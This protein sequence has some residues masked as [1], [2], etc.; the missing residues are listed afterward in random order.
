MLLYDSLGVSLVG[1]STLTKSSGYSF[2]GITPSTYAL[3]SV[4]DNYTTVADKKCLTSSENR[5]LTAIHIDN[6]TNANVIVLTWGREKDGAPTDL[7]SHLLASGGSASPTEVKYN[8]KGS[9]DNWSRLDRDDTDYI[10]PETISINLDS[11]SGP[12]RSNVTKACYIVRMYPTASE[13]STRRV[14]SKTG[15]Q[16]QIFQNDGTFLTNFDAPADDST[17]NAYWYV[18]DLD[19]NLNI[20]TKNTVSSSKPTCS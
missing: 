14:W 4:I 5:T 11:S 3:K 18:F 7:D 1:N 9:S 17:S 19:S 8:S 10:G 20:T 15:A 2:S 16:V 13:A 12:M 6:A